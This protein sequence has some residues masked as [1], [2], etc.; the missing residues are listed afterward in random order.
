MQTMIVNV[1]TI[2]SDSPIMGAIQWTLGRDVH[3]IA[4]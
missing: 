2:D 3:A 1:P 4:V